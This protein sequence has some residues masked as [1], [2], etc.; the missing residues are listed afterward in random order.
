M[1]RWHNYTSTLLHKTR[2]EQAVEHEEQSG[3]F[4]DVKIEHVFVEFIILLDQMEHKLEIFA[5][6]VGFVNVD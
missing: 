5:L 2:I 3:F 4:V 1:G 6:D